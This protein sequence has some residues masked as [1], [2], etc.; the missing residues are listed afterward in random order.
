MCARLNDATAPV[1]YQRKLWCHG[2]SAASRQS[3]SCPSAAESVA[4]SRQVSQGSEPNVI[5]SEVVAADQEERTETA[6]L[7]LALGTAAGII[8]GLGAAGIPLLVPGAL[9]P[10]PALPPIIR[11]LLPQVPLLDA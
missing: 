4:S 10:D 5:A 9:T 3:C 7:I 1:V 2:S 8:G 11:T 6:N